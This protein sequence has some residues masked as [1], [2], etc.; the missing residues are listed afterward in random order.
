M[1]EYYQDD[2]SGYEDAGYDDGSGYGQQE[3]YNPETHHWS[4]NPESW[5][6]NPHHLD[7]ANALMSALIQ[8]DKLAEAFLAA[9]EQYQQAQEGPP[10]RLDG[11]GRKTLNRQAAEFIR[12]GR[13]ER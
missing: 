9:V 11:P 10:A 5:V 8:D 3:A 6:H 4:Q 13:E 12:R 7:S 1:T 2:G